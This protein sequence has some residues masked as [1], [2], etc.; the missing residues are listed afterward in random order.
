MKPQDKIY[1][2]TSLEAMT[3]ILKEGLKAGDEGYIY[4]F[5]EK[6]VATYMAKN[7]L[8][9]T[10]SY[11]LLEINPKGIEVSLEADNVGEFTAKYQV[12]IKQKVILPEY[13]ILEGGYF[14]LPRQT[15]INTVNR[16][17]TK[18]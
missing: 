6:D 5:T 12:R 8:G 15:G 9:F 17:N 2:I 18:T 4:L 1:H 3:S 10:D 14:I 13:I 16:I 7:Q 11:Q